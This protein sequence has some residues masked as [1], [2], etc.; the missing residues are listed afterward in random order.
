MFGRALV[1]S[2]RDQLLE[3]A[4][5]SVSNVANREL[6]NPTIRTFVLLPFLG[7]RAIETEYTKIRF[8][9]ARDR[10]RVCTLQKRGGQPNDRA[11]KKIEDTWWH[12]GH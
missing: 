12:N 2:R 6:M 9:I 8:R 4:T 3:A 5:D 10:A 7:I 1:M 11:K